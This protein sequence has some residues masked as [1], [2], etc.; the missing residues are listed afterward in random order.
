MNK[1]SV[2]K[3]NTVYN[4]EK[5]P[6]VLSDGELFHI[7]NN[8]GVLNIKSPNENKILWFK[9]FS[10]LR[11]PG[12]YNYHLFVHTE[13]KLHYTLVNSRFQIDY[14]T[15]IPFEEGQIKNIYRFGINPLHE[16][17]FALLYNSGKLIVLLD[18]ELK[19]ADV[20]ESS[21]AFRIVEGENCGISV[22]FRGVESLTESIRMSSVCK[23]DDDVVFSDVYME[24]SEIKA[25]TTKKYEN[26][27]KW[28]YDPDNR[29][30]IMLHDD[31]ILRLLTIKDRTNFKIIKEVTISGVKDV[32]YDEVR[33]T[34]FI[35]KANELR[36]I[37]NSDLTNKWLVSG[38]INWYSTFE[39]K[40][41]PGSIL[42]SVAKNNVLVK[43][44]SK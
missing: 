13:G 10:A 17:Q 29:V 31:G 16:F 38:L 39:V 6:L 22:V 15:E 32:C 30:I 26:V 2:K 19:R 4:K 5:M 27:E 37:I 36:K 42:T 12:F 11:I 40:I 41:P 9:S 35:S 25:R 8:Y 20:D 14:W 33:S 7:S 23:V 28:F 18:R 44:A 34:Y 3:V 1:S 24:G 43:S 21:H